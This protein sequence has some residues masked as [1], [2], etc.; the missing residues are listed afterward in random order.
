[1]TNTKS[2][3][4]TDAV[5]LPKHKVNS[6]R[7]CA[8]SSIGIL[9][10]AAIAGTVVGVVVAGQGS[11]APPAPP[12]GT[13]QVYEV[14]G[15][16]IVQGTV[17]DYNTPSKKLAMAEVIANASS[18]EA[19]QVTITVAAASVRVEYAIRLDTEAAASS[20]ASALVATS[21]GGGGEGGIFATASALEQALRAGGVTG[22]TVESIAQA[23]TVEAVYIIASPPPP[24]AVPV[25]RNVMF[26]L[27]P[28]SAG[29][30]RRLLYVSAATDTATPVARS[31][32]GH[33]W[34]ALANGHPKGIPDVIA[35]A[36]TDPAS[37]CE[38]SLTAEGNDFYRLEAH[39]Y[40][41]PASSRATWERDA[42]RFLIQATF[43]PTRDSIANFSGEAS[44]ATFRQWIH[45]QM[46]EAP[47]LHR[48][49]YRR[50]SQPRL[51][52]SA[53]AT[54]ALRPACAPGSRWRRF[55][56]SKQDESKTLTI[57]R[58]AGTGAVEY[59][60]DGVLRTEVGADNLPPDASM[61]PN[62]LES[63]SYVLAFEGSCKEKVQGLNEC[64]NASKALGLTWKGRYWQGDPA[65][66]DEAVDDG[67]SSSGGNPPGCY[68][69]G[70]AWRVLKHNVAQ[71]NTGKCGPFRICICRAYV[72]TVTVDSFI[73]CR[74]QEKSHGD[75]RLIPYTSDASVAAA[76]CHAQGSWFTVRNPPIEQSSPDP[77]LSQTFGAADVVLQPMGH[78]FEPDVYI[79]QN[80]PPACSLSAQRA[81]SFMRVGTTWY[82]LD[83]TIEWE[84][85][86]VNSPA[87][88]DASALH[89]LDGH[90][91]ACPT[92]PKTFL[93]A[94]GCVRATTCAPVRYTSAM[95]T[96]NETTM[97]MYYAA[98]GLLIYQVR[99]LRLEGPYDVNPCDAGATS[100]WRRS[101]GACS[102]DTPLDAATRLSVE[103]ALTSSADPNPWFR[104]VDLS[105]DGVGSCT[106]T[107]DGVSTKAAQITINGSCWQHVHPDDGNVHAFSY[108]RLAHPGNDQFSAASNPIEAVIK[109]GSSTIHLPASHSMKE[110]WQ[111]S[112]KHLPLLGRYGDRVDFRD[113]PTYAQ[114]LEVAELL[115][116]SASAGDD[117]SEACGSPGEVAN[118]PTLGHRYRTYITDDERSMNELQ[119]PHNGNNGK[120]MVWT[121]IVLASDDQ[122]RQRMAWALSQIF[123]VGV[124]GL[125]KSDQ[126]EVWHTYY[127][128]FVRNAFGSY[129]DVLREVSYSPAMAHYLSFHNN[130]AFGVRRTNPDEN[131]AREIMQLF[132]IG[133]WML[134]DG[135]QPLVNGAAEPIATYTNVHIM[136]F[137]R[138]WTGFTR[139]PFRGNIEASDG[140]ASP[141]FI[142]PSRI[143]AT[144]RDVF[145]KMNLWSGYLGDGY[146]I[147]AE[148]PARNFLRA[149]ATY[150]YLGR[151]SKPRLHIGWEDIAPLPPSAL[152]GADILTLD[153]TASNLGAALCGGVDS[154]GAC[155]FPGEVTLEQHLTCHGQ[156]CDVDTVRVVGLHDAVAN[157]TTFYEYARPACVSLSFFPNGTEVRDGWKRLCL[158]PTTVS[159]GSTCCTS[160]SNNPSGQ[161]T[162]VEERVTAT[163]ARERC[164]DAGLEV[165][166]Y[167]A[168]ES[169]GC[170]YDAAYSWTSEPCKLQIQVDAT[171]GW[172]NQVHYKSGIE[173]DSWARHWY[174]RYDSNH[175]F[176][177]RWADGLYP[178]P[179]DGCDTGS[180]STTPC[181]V[182]S[183]GALSTCVCD[184]EVSTTAVFSQAPS[185]SEAL[186]Q[187]FIGSAAPAAFD[188][189][190]YV[191]C[192]SATCTQEAGVEVYTKSTSSGALD[193]DTIFRI[194]VN[195]TM[196][197]FA[198]KASVVRVGSAYSFRNPVQ[199]MNAHEPTVRD[200]MHET[201][202]LIEH[203]LYHP[204]TA[205]FVAHRLIQRLVS[206]NPSPRYIKAVGTAFSTGSYDGVSY[207]G[208]YGDLAAT[209]AAILLDREARSA[210]LDADPTHGQ[211]REPIVKVI[212]FMRALEFSS[213]DG[214][215]VE[216]H[217]LLDAIGQEVYNS[218][219]VFNFYLPEFQPN[220]PV[221]DANLYAPEAQL[222]TAPF[223][224]GFLNGVS[225]LVR[226]G[227]TT[228]ASGF[229]STAVASRS[230]SRRCSYVADPELNAT[231]GTNGDSVPFAGGADM[232]SSDGHLAYTPTSWDAAA[233]VDELALLLTA[234][235]LGSTGRTIIQDEYVHARDHGSYAIA[236]YHRD[237]EAYGFAT[238]TSMSECSQAAAV[239]GWADTSASDDNRN[240]GHLTDPR[241]C[242]GRGA[243]NPD[244]KFNVNDG[245]VGPCTNGDKCVCS[246][247]S[248][249]E[250]LR[251]ATQLVLTTAEFHATNLNVAAATARPPPSPAPSL[252]RPFK[253]VV[254]LFLAGGVDSWNLVVPHSGCDSTENGTAHYG[255]YAAMRGG[256]ALA[257][258]D[259]LPISVPSGSQPCT[260]FGVHPA[261][262]LVKT[263]Y[264]DGDAAFLANIGALV[265]PITKAQYLAKEKRVPPSLFAHNTQ[266]KV[267]QSVHAQNTVAR[268]VLGR[269]VDALSDEEQPDPYK[270]NAYSVSG[271]AKILE[272]EHRAQS[273]LD[274][275]SGVVRFEDYPRLQRAIGNLSRAVSA[276]VFGETFTSLLDESLTSTENLGAV[277]DAVTIDTA[278]G[279]DSLS[280][281][282]EQVARMVKARETLQ[283]ERQAFFV[284]LGGFDTHASELDTVQEKF[285]QVNG[286]LGSFV[287]ELKAQGVWEQTTI[288]TASDFGRTLGSNGAGTDHAWG[289]HHIVMGG[290]VKGGQMLGQYPARLDEASDVNIGRN[291]RMLPTMPW[292]ALWN[293]IALWF[294][295]SSA[296]V[297]TI[298]PNAA[299]F[300]EASLLSLS[301]LMKPARRR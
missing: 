270:A 145:P 277:L 278:F 170:G 258:S 229:G 295:A 164:T 210:T 108:W 88:F 204:N 87:V 225:S 233:V 41:P 260:T 234:G 269:L 183:N 214:R 232:S 254:V 51:P 128:V 202:A 39:N 44:D 243:D 80:A 167:V 292:E 104:D 268:G 24:P 111:K 55:A 279:T 192:T 124:E 150:Q 203:L 21:G 246:T 209:V 101:E 251:V 283:E 259:L 152:A 74:V 184:V 32:D 73:I 72:P 181:A 40:S 215:E 169:H 300:P 241:G 23:P 191:L 171:D 223:L 206:S 257:Q 146:P 153:A 227:L 197:H 230:G 75:V 265:E 78:R 64:T 198:N 57:Q 81:A 178:T 271:I 199:F 113:L 47:S 20:T 122:L 97:E 105:V 83:R 126:N 109:S 123:V 38:A 217:A 141:N 11:A 142:D 252:G 22:V 188:T 131:Y 172:I 248:Q 3:V 288:V 155:A 42:A 276:S 253:A 219:T 168:S 297:P 10:A 95:M 174:L 52:D 50:R 273:V 107:H 242:Y 30:L 125:T 144:W 237:C 289:G 13:I 129:R 245:N 91:G 65:A 280:R 208:E 103:V 9:L 298:I 194:N 66:S 45:A 121:T 148:L 255:T 135:G 46:L 1:M 60:I 287:A 6:R 14:T 94:N 274:P 102:S 82:A 149:G 133:L 15:A 166:S 2:Q 132:T 98:A 62:A 151:T 5:V 159:A 7:L 173:Y 281:Q 228:C 31:Y 267:T 239:L 96:L 112:R 235:R 286:A 48:A 27:P 29:V 137:A 190:E 200:A 117:G 54:S 293:G 213:R 119:V 56:L 272:M 69:T 34:E 193:E 8:L 236:R 130:L 284:E 120:E 264:D 238:L 160:G 222:G 179:A 76:A 163:T 177:V 185:K 93:N 147:C 207:S 16:F 296:S 110:R 115:G 158:D 138:A 70:Q 140:A 37:T 77:T 84:A 282:L 157:T 162:Y 19:E 187:L 186:A 180:G 36:C 134:D 61:N 195:G 299:N 201:D 114:P 247:R 262:P 43:G 17:D 35:Q 256:V 154:E 106:A 216:L 89:T 156:E 220:G 249:E 266:V 85:N 294:G 196:R 143:R 63:D 218:P 58:D 240:V 71:G 161:C 261:L 99:G 212:H 4:H 25:V 33:H 165:C 92:V 90:R 263:L 231:S 182:R 86:T 26:Q 118:D 28:S 301:Q 68:M 244:V 226:F 12:P 290:D 100:R 127:D 49:H 79:L 139:Q 59:R 285:E 136:N 175:L 211:L 18:V 291:H 116:A 224:M 176:P 67:H 275:R 53:R 205:P 250:A 189:N 221:I